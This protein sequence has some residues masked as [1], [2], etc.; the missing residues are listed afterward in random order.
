MAYLILRT[1]GTLTQPTNPAHVRHLCN[2]MILTDKENWVS[3]GLFGGAYGKVI[4]WSFEKQGLSTRRPG[5]R[6]GHHR[7][8]AAGRGRVYR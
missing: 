5:S 6:H 4:R 8:P 3:E 2:A 7:G 1:V